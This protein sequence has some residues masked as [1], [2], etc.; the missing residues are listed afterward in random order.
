MSFMTPLFP[1][2][3]EQGANFD[4]TL[5]WFG[6][7]KFIAPIEDITL[8]YPTIISVTD[9]L[10]NAVSPTPVIISGTDGLPHLNSSDTSIAIATKIDADTFSVALSTVGDT[11]EEGTGEI[12]YWKPTDL[13]S[14]TAVMNIRKN[15]YATTVLKTL[16]TAL[17]TLVLG[18]LDGSCQML[19]SAADTALLTFVGGVYDID[20]TIGGI[21]T[22][23]FRGPIKLH[24]DI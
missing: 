9:H 24:R 2:H 1:L 3:L 6:G 7:G 15:W 17:G 11:W 8:G 21:V 23:V 10:L 4:H 20:F 12:T 13:T 5:Q 16:S 18:P 14:Y 19:I 22:R